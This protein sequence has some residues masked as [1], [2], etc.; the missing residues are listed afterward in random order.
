[1][2]MREKQTNK[3]KHQKD[4][5]KKKLLTRKEDLAAKKLSDSYH[6]QDS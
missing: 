2:V 3:P 5:E 4:K 6:L 1:M